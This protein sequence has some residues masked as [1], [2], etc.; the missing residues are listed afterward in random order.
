MVVEHRGKQVVCCCHRMEVA[1]EMQ[2][3]VLH[4]NHL[5]VPTSRGST[6]DAK[7]GPH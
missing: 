3:Q 6:F 7:G 4:G 2:V 1:R 5:A